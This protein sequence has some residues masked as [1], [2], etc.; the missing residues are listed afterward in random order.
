VA[1]QLVSTDLPSEKERQHRTIIANAVNDLIKVRPPND[2]TEAEVGAGVTPIRPAYDPGDIR[3]YWGG[4][5]IHT[6]F[7]MANDQALEDGAPI[8]IPRGEWT[9][10]AQLVVDANV[11]LV[12]ERGAVIIYTGSDETPILVIGD[13]D[14][15]TVQR[16]YTGIRV[17]RQSQSDWTNELNMAVRFVNVNRSYIEVLEAANCTIGVQ[18]FGQSTACAINEVHLG[19]L[20]NNKYGL[21]LNNDDNTGVGYTNSNS[22]FGGY[23]TVDTG[24]NTSLDRYGIRIMTQAGSAYYNNDNK[25]YNHTFELNTAGSGQAYP[26]LI[27]YGVQNEFYGLRDELNDL[28]T[29]TCENNSEDNIAYVTYGSSTIA[30]NGAYTNNFVFMNRAYALQRYTAVWN[31]PGPMHKRANDYDGAGGAVYFWDASIMTSGAGT[32]ARSGTGF[33]FSEDYVSFDSGRAVGVLLDVRQFKRY[34][35]SRD[36]GS[37]GGR[38]LFA[39]YD[40][41]MSQLNSGGGA[42]PYAQSG[43]G[44]TLS[45]DANFGGC[46]QTGG[47][48]TNDIYASFKSAVAYVWVGIVG[49]TNPAQLRSISIQSIDGGSISVCQGIADSGGLRFYNDGR[50]YAT[51]QPSTDNGIDYAV[52][53]RINRASAVAAGAPGWIT[54]TAGAPGTAV[55]KTE[56]AVAP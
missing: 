4:G 37:N 10:S 11:D 28:P 46:Y 52:G 25:F 44:T 47:D 36:T 29:M 15:V 30:N 43:S 49:G 14:A 17:Q 38:W 33:T 23:F 6:A 24:V 12:F 40:S 34:I 55:F 56:A 13:F 2:R 48:A 26:I 19:L 39:C 1:T 42:H 54:T 50:P 22:F 8:F 27:S 53:F 31:P 9:T 18:L 20:I 16:K 35:F 45:Y 41:S 32:Q 7:Q 5:S 3:R 51:N 21:D